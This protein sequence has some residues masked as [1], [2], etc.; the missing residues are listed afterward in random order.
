[1]GKK[2]ILRV[3]DFPKKHRKRGMGGP[4]TAEGLRL[5]RAFMKIENP[6]RRAAII[7]MVEEA[8]DQPDASPRKTTDES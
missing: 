6:V 3:S 7:S 1:M 8:A 2:N 4:T 5:L